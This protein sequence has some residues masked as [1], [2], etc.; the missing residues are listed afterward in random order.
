MPLMRPYAAYLGVGDGQVEKKATL[1]WGSD[2]T[3]STRTPPLLVLPPSPL[4][5]PL[6]V[7]VHV[8]DNSPHKGDVVDGVRPDGPPHD[9][10]GAG[11]GTSLRNHGA[12]AG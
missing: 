1:W 4:L 2:H 11:F 12:V 3:R 8:S 5:L 9:P 10:A 7:S 6:F